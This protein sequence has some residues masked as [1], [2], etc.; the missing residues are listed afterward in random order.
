MHESVWGSLDGWRDGWFGGKQFN[1]QNPLWYRQLV[2]AGGGYVEKEIYHGGN[3]HTEK[4]CP[5]WKWRHGVL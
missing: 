2:A 3:I 4:W 1:H 5:G